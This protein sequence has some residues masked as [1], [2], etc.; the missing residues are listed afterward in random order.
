MGGS[1]LLRALGRRIV[2][3][4]GRRWASGG[5][6]EVSAMLGETGDKEKVSA[7]LGETGDK[8]KVSAMLGETGDKEK[9]SA[10]LGE[11]GDKEKVSAM[12][13]ETG[14]KEKVSAMLG[15]TGDKEKVSA[16]LGET[17]DKEKV[18]AM[19]GETGD[20]EKVS[21]MLGETGDKEKVSAMLGETGDKEKVSAML[22]ETGDKEKVSAMLGET[23]DKEKVSAM[24][25]ETGDKEKVSAMLGETGDKEKVSAMLGET[26]GKEKVSAMLGETGGKE[27]V[28]AM[29]GETGGKEKVS[30]M[31]GETGGKEKVSAMLGE[32]GGKEKVSAMLGETGGKEKVSAILG[33]AYSE[34]GENPLSTPRRSPTESTVVLFPGQGSQAVGMAGGLLKY[35]N[36][37]EMFL[38]ARKV[39]GY[40]LL[41]LCLRGPATMLEQTVHCQPAMFVTSVA[42]TE[43]LSQESPAALEQCVAVAGFSVG[44]FAALV[45]SGAL[46]FTEA[47]YAVKVRAEAMQK[48][49][50]AVLSGMLSVIG[51]AKTAYGSACADAREHCL[52]LGIKEPVCE[53]AN[54]LFPN[55]RVIAGHMEAIQFLQT[56]SR[57]Y[58]FSRTKLLPVSG[59][60]HT[61][62]MAPAVE[63]LAEA[64]KGLT[65][66]KPLVSI[67]SN[68][69]GKRYRHAAAI[70]QLL[71]QQLVSPVKWEQTMHAI[72]ERRKGSHF[73][74][75]YELGPG[76]QLGTILKT[77]NLK[78]WRSY[79]LVNVFQKDDLEPE[80]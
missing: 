32:T 4:T 64:L 35:P 28:S 48:A 23:G 45:F 2:V 27:K 42:A 18:S 40:D 51:S 3:Y 29:L 38:V 44:E 79:S 65:F 31:L 53:V 16:M 6:K 52:S 61:R 55:G 17:G 73:P 39:L 59:A 69:D 24:L 8:E 67:Y 20:K 10:M 80:H 54:Y 22:G 13:G 21:A 60:F 68:V 49:S 56:H 37:R 33:E 9:V 46:D 19:L 58:H 50:E 1:A 36:V 71:A 76:G 7:M 78:A 70:P 34:E 5:D 66:R 11:T 74:A 26:G 41:E 47:L 43:K 77:C 75:T 72:Y 25:G 62:L 30:A 15:E 12:L 63:P 57:K 14:D